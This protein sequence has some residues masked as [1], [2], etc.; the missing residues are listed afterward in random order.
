MSSDDIYNPFVA[1]EL[2]AYL[3]SS[4]IQKIKEGS[5]IPIDTAAFGASHPENWCYFYQ[6]ASLAAQYGKWDTAMSLWQQAVQKGFQ[7]K[8][9]SEFVPFIKAAAYTGNWDLAL[10]LSG[11]AYT[12]R[13]QMQNYLCH[14]W[15]EIDQAAIA[16]DGLN[17]AFQKANTD[18]GCKK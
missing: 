10:E 1:E 14:I 5:D 6:K 9:A 13:E 15:T 16:S 17:N 11:R 8:I 2:K 7:P 18:F 3:P 4:N 12:P